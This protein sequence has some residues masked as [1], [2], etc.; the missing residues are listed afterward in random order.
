MSGRRFLRIIDLYLPKYR[1]L[2]PRKQQTSLYVIWGCRQGVNDNCAVLGYYAASTGNFLSTFRDNFTVPFSSVKIQFW[3]L[4]MGHIGCPETLVINYHYSLR[5]NPEKCS[6]KLHYSI[7]QT[8]KAS[9]QIYSPPALTLKRSVFFDSACVLYD[10]Q[11]NQ[12]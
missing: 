12:W 7:F 8:F 9:F 11:S 5:N 6:Y 3:P 4:K 1:Q 2:D 10:C